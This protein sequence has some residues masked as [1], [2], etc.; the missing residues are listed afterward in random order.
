MLSRLYLLQADP[1]MPEISPDFSAP[2]FTGLVMIASWVL[3]G[4]FVL[5]FIALILCIAALA[6]KGITPDK[7]RAAAGAGLP[8]VIGSVIG[9]A[10]VGGIFTWLVGLD[11]GFGTVLGGA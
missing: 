4:G 11:F 9:L 5:A 10:A 6:L 3:A 7:M 8:I 2:F 1:N